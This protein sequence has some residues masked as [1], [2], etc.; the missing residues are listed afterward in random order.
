MMTLTQSFPDL[1][2]AGAADRFLAECDPKGF[3]KQM[4]SRR[5]SWV[6][7]VPLLV[8][9]AGLGIGEDGNFFIYVDDTLGPKEQALELG[10]EIA[11]TFHHNM[12]KTPP[13]NFL[14]E[15]LK[16]EVERFCDAFA[17]IWVQRMGT[18]ALAS[19][20]ENEADLIFSQGIMQEQ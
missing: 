4:R 7:I 14:E 10:H 20:F 13:Q 17:S 18:E 15:A 5:I 8:S 11:H 19:R 6:K 1:R 12:T 16:D 3:N 9:D 2:F